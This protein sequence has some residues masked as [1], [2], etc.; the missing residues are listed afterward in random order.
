MSKKIILLGSGEL[1]KEFTISAKRYGLKVIAVDKYKSAPAM[2][3]A[4]E[5]EVIDMLD[6]DELERIIQKH[7]PDLII[8]EIEAIRTEK[9]FEFEERGIQV[10]PSAKAVNYTMDRKAIRDLAATELGLRT[11]AFAYAK[12]L[13]EIKEAVAEIGIP[14]VV[15]PLMSS[16]G[17]GQSVIKEEA[18][19]E[20]A[21]TY[22]CEGSRGDK[23]EVIVEEFIRFEGLANLMISS[24]EETLKVHVHNFFR[25]LNLYISFNFYFFSFRLFKFLLFSRDGSNSFLFAKMQIKCK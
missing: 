18:D 12:S 3:V 24:F 2:Q 23:M 7:Q 20:K 11:A 4:D 22:A 21:W 8:P 1:G 19:I 17:K 10:V 6:P 9:L 25:F 14:C 15:K 5:F 16:S 13:E